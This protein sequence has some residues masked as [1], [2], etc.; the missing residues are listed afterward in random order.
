MLNTVLIVDDYLDARSFLKSLFELAGYRV[1]EAGDGDEAVER[2][3]AE[4]PDLILMDMS[5]PGMDG[6]TASRII[7]E[8]MT[9]KAPTIVGVTTHG[10]V[11]HEKATAADCKTALNKPVAFDTLDSVIA[12]YITN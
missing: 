11:Y 2:A 4:Q 1:V 6:L 8:K 7:K 5:M 10:Y 3:Q 9:A 12:M